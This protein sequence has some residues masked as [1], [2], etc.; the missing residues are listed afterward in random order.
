LRA[1]IV[2]QCRHEITAQAKASAAVAI[3]LCQDAED[4]QA[5]IDMLNPNPFASQLTIEGFLLWREVP[6]SGFLLGQ[7]RVDRQLL[8]PLIAFILQTFGEGMEVNARG[9]E[10]LE[11]MPS[12]FAEKGADDLFGGSVKHQLAFERITFVFPRIER[13]LTVFRT[14]DGRFSHIHDDDGGRAKAAPQL[15]FSRE[16]KSP[17][18]H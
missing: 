3:A 7:A 14:L 10:Q 4:F 17:H 1:F 5:A 16:A 2:V 9:F 12:S 6:T 13:S 11:V 18:S 8:H 15:S